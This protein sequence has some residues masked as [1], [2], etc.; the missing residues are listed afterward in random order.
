MSMMH[1]TQSDRKPLF[2]PYEAG[3]SLAA[4]WRRTRMVA[5]RSLRPE[6]ADTSI[7]WEDGEADRRDER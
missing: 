3:R 1:P 7:L 4:W 2:D 6:P 5:E